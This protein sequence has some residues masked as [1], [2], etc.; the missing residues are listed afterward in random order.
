MTITRQI[1]PP[2]TPEVCADFIRRG[3]G[4]VKGDCHGV[5][6]EEHKTA[7]PYLHWQRKNS[8]VRVNTSVCVHSGEDASARR[9]FF[10]DQ[11][12]KL[13]APEWI[14]AAEP[15]TFIRDTKD[16]KKP[17]RRT[18]SQ[19]ATALAE[20]VKELAELNPLISC[21]HTPITEDCVI[22]K[23]GKICVHGMAN[24]FEC[25]HCGV[26]PQSKMDRAG[27][28]YHE[29]A[30]AVLDVRSGFD[31]D[32]VTAVPSWSRSFAKWVSGTTKLKTTI[33]SKEKFKSYLENIV[34][35][36]VI[37]RKLK[38]PTP[39][40]SSSDAL[41]PYEL[42]A[43][44]YMSRSDGRQ[45]REAL[46][47]EGLTAETAETLLEVYQ[48]F[49][50]WVLDKFEQ[51]PVWNAIE[52]LA[53]LLQQQ[54]TVTGSEVQRIVESHKNDTELVRMVVAA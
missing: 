23:Q 12:A 36:D 41:S 25:F 37:Q 28:S 52:E 17:L 45:F 43:M 30:H 21:K 31:V 18:Q 34:A 53:Q 5:D 39:L 29:A 8:L 49:E 42:C 13:L 16:A 35:G 4:W 47:P 9:G 3:L 14:P 27:T 7:Q 32:K 46:R 38:F 50:S 10:M 54:D 26:L 1:V 33:D 20:A 2:I 19:N 22:C 48:S 24:R 51:P 44:V 40:K 6:S 11:L 15:N